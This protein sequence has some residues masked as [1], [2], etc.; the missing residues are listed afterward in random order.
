M[1]TTKD[2]SLTVYPTR[3]QML[4]FIRAQADVGTGERA[5]ERRSAASEARA[6]ACVFILD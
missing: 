2:P 3:E 1:I 6:P 4:A 5:M